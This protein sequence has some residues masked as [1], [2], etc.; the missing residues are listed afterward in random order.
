MDTLQED[1]IKAIRSHA[2]ANYENSGW[3]YVVE[4]WDDDE[5]IEE[6]NGCNSIEAAILKVGNIVSIMDDHRK[7]IQATAF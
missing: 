6:I 7:D 4:C 3:D 1:M 5:I 2:N